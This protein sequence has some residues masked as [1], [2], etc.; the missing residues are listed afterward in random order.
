MLGYT[1][2]LLV[3]TI[4][5]S[6]QGF[7]ITWN[8]K[9]MIPML[10]FII[11]KGHTVRDKQTSSLSS[12]CQVF[13]PIHSFL[14]HRQFL[15]RLNFVCSYNLFRTFGSSSALCRISLKQRLIK[16]QHS[17]KDG[18]KT[19]LG[20]STLSLTVSIWDTKNS[21][22]WYGSVKSFPSLG[23]RMKIVHTKEVSYNYDDF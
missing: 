20:S 5:K 8:W 7:N 4:W 19:I 16:S 14:Y 1:H 22:S 11:T 2:S 17:F 21:I 3:K 12:I 6:N 18:S 13:C 23:K 9:I 10:S 15:F